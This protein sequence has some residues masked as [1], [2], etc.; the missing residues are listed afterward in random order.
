MIIE[1][2]CEILLPLISGTAD[3]LLPALPSGV[4]DVLNTIFEYMADGFH[5]VN[6]FLDTGLCINLIAWYVA[7]GAVILTVEL[8]YS[9]WHKITGNAGSDAVTETN[10]IYPDGSVQTTSSHRRSRP[11]LPRF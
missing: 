11:H 10:T 5:I 6:F 3:L 9:V 4:T 2:L 8:F 7:F 1:L